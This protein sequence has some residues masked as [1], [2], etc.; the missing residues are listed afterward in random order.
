[1]ICNV[2]GHSGFNDVCLGSISI[3]TIRKIVVKM[4]NMTYDENFYNF[5]FKKW[6]RAS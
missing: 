6:K 4:K 1:M 2:E 3:D 5:F